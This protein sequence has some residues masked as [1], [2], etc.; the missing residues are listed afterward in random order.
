V[1]HSERPVFRWLERGGGEAVLLLHGLIGQMHHWD[2]VLDQLAD[3]CRPLALSLPFL[4][5]PLRETSIGAIARYVVDFLDALDIGRAV[6]GGNSLGGHVALELALRYPERVS[7]LILTGSS[8]LMERSFTRGVPRRPSTEYIRRE[9]EEVFYD[10]GL[11]TQEWVEAVRTIVMTPDSARRVL[12]L[13]RAA[14][15]HNLQ[16]WLGGVAVPTLL[17]WGREDRITPAEIGQRFLALLPDAQ[18]WFLSHC[19]HAPMLEQPESFADIVRAW[20]GETR[21]RRLTAA[22][23]LRDR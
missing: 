19:G 15:R 2:C 6:V 18:L 8:G 22:S 4:D 11:V 14:R 23:S 12:R 9:L 21:S 13:A 1:E 7:G 20:L 5:E 10:A 16:A 3:H 17:I